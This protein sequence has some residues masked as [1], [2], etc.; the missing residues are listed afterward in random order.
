MSRIL[1]DWEV[2][3]ALDEGKIIEVWIDDDVNKWII[4][5]P[6]D[7][8]EYVSEINS[9]ARYRLHPKYERI[10]KLIKEGEGI[11]SR[12]PATLIDTRKL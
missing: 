6:Q 1:K 12:M 10:D 5:D 8:T 4:P 11:I 3:K 2:L 9:G 7:R